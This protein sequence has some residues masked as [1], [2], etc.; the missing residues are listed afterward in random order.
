[1]AKNRSTLDGSNGWLAPELNGLKGGF[2]GTDSGRWAWVLSL[3][4][5]LRGIERCPFNKPRL[6][7]RVATLDPGT[8]LVAL[9]SRA[10]ANAVRPQHPLRSQGLRGARCNCCQ[11]GVPRATGAR[12]LGWCRFPDFSH[13]VMAFNGSGFRCGEGWKSQD[14]LEEA[15]RTHRQNLVSISV[16]YHENTGFDER[17]GN[18]EGSF[19][20]LAMRK[21]CREVVPGVGDLRARVGLMVALGS[22][23]LGSVEA[24]WSGSVPDNPDAGSG[25]PLR[26]PVEPLPE[27]SETFFGASGNQALEALVPDRGRASVGKSARGSARFSPRAPTPINN[28]PALGESLLPPGEIA[29]D[30]GD[31]ALL[32]AIIEGNGLTE[33]SSASDDDNGD[34]V[35]EPLELGRQVWRNGRLVQLSLGPDPYQPSGYRIQ[36]LPREIGLLSELE[37]LDLHGEELTS[38][39]ESIG[40]LYALREFRAGG[41]RLERLPYGLRRLRSLR[42]LVLTENQLTSLP[43][44]IGD[45]AELEELRVGDND[46]EALPEGLLALG[47]LRELDLAS[48]E[49]GQRDRPDAGPARRAIARRLT[50]LPDRI[51]EMPALQIIHVAG[52][53]ICDASDRMALRRTGLIVFGLGA[54]DCGYSDGSVADG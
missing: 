16:G 52:H 39:P 12:N 10:V 18:V 26:A 42:S 53:R 19:Y 1:M 51:A 24:G 47:S 32:A 43:E 15:F 5:P 31:L 3:S 11:V 14:A 29:R 13:S 34:G 50:S 20:N 25:E 45:L 46:L 2:G 6:Q 44:E 41:N 4:S 9:V 30:P 27:Y 37:V 7:W 8:V 48:E 54:Q 22:L 33:D 36:T 17:L 49:P 38:L 28:T 35:L 21:I 23:V 40:D